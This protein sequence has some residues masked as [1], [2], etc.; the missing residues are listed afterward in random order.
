MINRMVR[1]APAASMPLGGVVIWPARAEDDVAR[2]I[3]NA[4]SPDPFS[5]YGLVD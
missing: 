2:Q 3:V 4:A 5:V 1:A